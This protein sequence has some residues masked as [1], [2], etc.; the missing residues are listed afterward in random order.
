MKMT[1]L[2]ISLLITLNFAFAEKVIVL[3]DLVN[4]NSIIIDKNNMY[5]TEDASVYI[6]SLNDFKLLKNL[7]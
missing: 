5:I 1:S 7:K 6:Y 4:P 3:P 2:I